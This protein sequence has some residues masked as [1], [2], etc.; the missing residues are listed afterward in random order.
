MTSSHKEWPST[1]PPSHRS[2]F[3]MSNVETDLQCSKFGHPKLP[4][5]RLALR[6][7]QLCHESSVSP[8]RANACPNLCHQNLGSLGAA[9]L[10]HCLNWSTSLS[11]KHSVER[12]RY[13]DSCVSFYHNVQ[14]IG[15]GHSQSNYLPNGQLKDGMNFKKLFN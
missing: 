2:I 3:S 9:L 6:G 8:R 1:S 15:K 7:R 5:M 4:A 13:S 10:R 11:S 14:G 12:T